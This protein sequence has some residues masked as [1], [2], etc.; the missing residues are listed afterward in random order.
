MHTW[1]ITYNA[2]SKGNPDASYAG[3]NKEITLRAP[4]AA[5]ALEMA[6]VN[7]P[8]VIYPH[9]DSFEI[10]NIQVKEL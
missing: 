8:S 10:V 2:H 6:K 4:T 5:D 3:H 9:F 1:K 7:I